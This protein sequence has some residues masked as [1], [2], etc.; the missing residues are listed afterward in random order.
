MDMLTP[1]SL[2]GNLTPSFCSIIEQIYVERVYHPK[3][4]F[5]VVGVLALYYMVPGV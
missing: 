1:P 5:V 4:I 3:F 2:L